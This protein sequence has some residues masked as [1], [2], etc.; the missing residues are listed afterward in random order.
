MPTLVDTIICENIRQEANNKVSLLGVFGDEVLVP[1]FPHQ[2]PSLAVFQRWTL[3][4]EEY[5]RGAVTFRIELRPPQGDSIV[6]PD[7]AT[8]LNPA[9]AHSV[10]IAIQLGGLPVTN[11]GTFSVVTFF[12][13]HEAHV[14]RF[15]IRTPS[16]S[17]IEHLRLSGF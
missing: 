2:F 5:R 4:D 3:S 9:S 17:E 16:R 8:P 10:N 14:H 15:T 7:N 11:K 12:D 13:N 1:H 6:L